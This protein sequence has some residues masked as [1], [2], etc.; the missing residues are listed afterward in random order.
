M[1]LVKHLAPTGHPG[2]TA[3]AEPA[4]ALV[5]EEAT[6]AF[7]AVLAE[8]QLAATPYPPLDNDQRRSLWAALTPVA[9]AVEDAEVED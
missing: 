8:G 5:A 9:N 7:A 1:C 3:P 2:N 4:G 6:R